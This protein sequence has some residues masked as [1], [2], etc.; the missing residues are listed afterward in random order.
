MRSLLQSFDTLLIWLNEN[1]GINTAVFSPWQST[2]KLAL[3][4]WLNEN[5][6]FPAAGVCWFRRAAIREARL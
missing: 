5:V 4:I 2:S 6:V 3:L 1:V